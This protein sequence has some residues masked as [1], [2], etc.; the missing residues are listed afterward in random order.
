VKRDGTALIEQLWSGWRSAYVAGD[1]VDA[2][3]SFDAGAGSGSVFTQLLASGL[4]DDETHIVHRGDRCFAIMNAFP[5]TN[6]HLLVLPYRE[7]ADLL[8][9]DAAE[10]TE[11]WATV[12]TA[13]GAV[14]RAMQPDGVNVG[15]NLG[16]ASGGS[17]PTHVHVHVVPRWTGDTNFMASIANT[18]SIPESLAV[19]AAK[20]R[21]AWPVTQTPS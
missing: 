16:R 12:T 19:S 11:L 18:T 13:V 1:A 15:V 8:D 3:A 17:V 2:R 14:R 21:A 7:V 6:G 20:V 10:T 9:L 4:S 5:Y